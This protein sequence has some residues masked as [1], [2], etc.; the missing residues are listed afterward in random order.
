MDDLC[1][2]SRVNGSEYDHWVRDRANHLGK[3]SDS[4]LS[5]KAEQELMQKNLYF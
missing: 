2:N 4:I 1:V 5:H 3:P